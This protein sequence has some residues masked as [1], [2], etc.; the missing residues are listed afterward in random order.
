MDGPIS[1]DAGSVRAEPPKPP[2]DP[3][4][5]LTATVGQPANGAPIPTSV[6]GIEVD[7]E[8]LR[9]ALEFALAFAVAS[10]KMRP[11]VP[12]PAGLRPFL[13]FQKLPAGALPAVRRTI[14]EDAEFRG[15]V[16]AAAAANEEFIG[17]LGVLWLRRP[18][19]WEYELAHL[20]TD[21]L[22]AHERHEAGRAE[23]SALK[24]LEAAEQAAARARADMAVSAEETA[25]ER[26]RRQV[27]EDRVKAAEAA[28]ASLE[29]EL[30]AARAELRRFKDQA[31]AARE[32]LTELK[33]RH[34]DLLARHDA[35][36][37]RLDEALAA[38]VAAE[39]RA[40][41]SS[42]SQRDHPAL[43]AAA[44]A[45][46]DAAAAMARV[47]AA[48][49]DTAAALGAAGTASPSSV[50]PL[51]DGRERR[52]GRPVRTPL[53]I[54]GGLY[55]SDAEVAAYLLRVPGV[56]LVVDGYNVAKTAW[57]DVELVEQRERLLESLEDLVRRQ[58]TRV[59][60]VFDG[61][62]VVVPAKP[63]RLVHVRFSPPGVLADDVIREFVADQPV[64]QAI[65]VAT[66]DN[67]VVNS[68][69]AM[70]ANTISSAQ[71]VGVIAR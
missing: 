17:S 27:A 21:E 60:V 39:A 9:P 32:S 59:H 13:K 69:R 36:E 51:G 64:E 66:S 58:G 62:D 16:A 14:D 11:P 46:R 15:R 31:S 25:R 1:D 41:G 37:A 48:V 43:G 30:T 40:G 7:D 57:P 34:A 12:A 6:G 67:A 33:D 53:S 65:V 18:A 23:R 68:V 35:L 45:L 24:R 29:R 28:N 22:A 10:Q 52:K 70:G 19:G 3:A 42:P 20:A 4:A 5:D 44:S 2:V 8:L 63:R 55:H 50:T 49:T 26:R 47:A 54:P 71:L 61:A 38:K 56:L